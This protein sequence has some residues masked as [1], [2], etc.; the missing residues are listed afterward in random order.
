MHLLDT[1][2]REKFPK[3]VE[4]NVHTGRTNV[5]RFA[6]ISI[7]IVRSVLVS[8]QLATKFS[9]QLYLLAIHTTI[10]TSDFTLWIR[11][12][13]VKMS[14]SL[15]PGADEPDVNK[16]PAILAACSTMTALALV[17]V[18]ARI[19]VRVK[20]VHSAGLDVRFSSC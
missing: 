3:H 2:A 14:A 5:V 9:L 13:V 11:Q 6:R 10:S 20:M 16:G 12:F 17:S 18:C 1:E 7:E 19:L 8:I 4:T 15:L